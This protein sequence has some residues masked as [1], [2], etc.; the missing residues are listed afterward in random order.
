MRPFINVIEFGADPTG[1]ADSLAAF[2]SA[3]RAAVKSNRYLKIIIPSG[4]YVLSDTWVVDHPVEIEGSGTVFHHCSTIKVYPGRDGM[5]VLYPSGAGAKISR[6]KVIP[7]GGTSIWVSGL[8]CTPELTTAFPSSG[9]A[10]FVYRCKATRGTHRTGATE[11]VW[12]TTEGATVRDGDVVWVAVYA[13]G[14]KLLGSAQVEDVFVSGFAGDGF[15]VPAS[16][17]DSNNANGWQFNRCLATGCA[18]WGF[19]TVGAD[20]NA[21]IAINCLTL[22][23]NLGGFLESSALGN[24][25]VQCLAEG[26]GVKGVG[27]GF[28][29]PTDAAVNNSLFLG[30]YLEGGQSSSINGKAMW[31]GGVEGGHVYGSGNIIRNAFSNTLYFLN[32]TRNDGTGDSAYIRV[33]RIGSQGVLE[34]GYSQNAGGI[35]QP[36]G[37][38]YGV[39]NGAAIPGWVGWSENSRSAWA[40]SI[41][42]AAEGG[43]HFWIPNDFYFGPHQ[44]L[45]S[46]Y[47]T[48]DSRG[49]PAGV[50]QTGDFCHELSLGATGAYGFSC[51]VGTDPSTGA[52]AK[53]GIIQPKPARAVA[54]DSVTTPR[55]FYIGVTNLAAQR[56][57]TLPTGTTIADGF[58][59]VIKDETGL[60]GNPN[61]IRVSPGGSDNLNG[62]NT[63]IAITQPYGALRVIRRN[64]AWWTI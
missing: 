42:N 61:E 48:K 11:P 50:F 9:Y 23:N 10:G 60:A 53:W 21:G 19:H 36:I 40:M 45:R 32:D 18:G 38:G 24:T 52:P 49:F 44:T 2:E 28:L 14:I 29:V 63:H 27:I 16:T 20:A 43:G 57:I 47:A 56:I 15:S 34:M 4:E 25:Y 33:G 31:F 22:Q 62:N 59:M 46:R 51:I 55:D 41:G 17:G 30:C 5:R 6:L 54:G 37:F 3:M 26:N 39:V 58:E 64:N 13:A 8:P 1:S 35:H 7:H 12:P